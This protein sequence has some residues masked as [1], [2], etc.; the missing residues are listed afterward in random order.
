MRGQITIFIITI[1][2]YAGIW[3]LNPSNKA[4]LVMFAFF[5]GTLFAILR[6]VRL[7][8]LFGYITSCVILTGK[9]YEIQLI[10][11]GIFPLDWWPNGYL[12]KFIIT[13][14]HVIGALMIL[15]MFFVFVRK[16]GYQR[17]SVSVIDILVFGYFFWVL[18]SSLFGSGQ[19]EI[20]LIGVLLFLN[21]LVAYTFIRIE[22]LT[23]S[24]VAS[25]VTIIMAIV[26]F[27]SLIAGLQLVNHSPIG[28]TVESQLLLEDFGEAVDE[29]SFRFRP[30]GTYPH[31]NELGLALVFFMSI[32]AAWF[33]VTKSK[34]PYI[35]Y[36]AGLFTVIAT[37]SR[38][39]WLALFFSTILIVANFR[40]QLPRALFSYIYRYRY[41]LLLL[42]IISVVV[43]IVPR[44]ERSLYS[45]METGGGGYIRKLQF[46]NALTL[47][48]LHPLFGVGAGMNVPEGLAL[49]RFG[50]LASFPASVH[51]LYLLIA[52]ENGIPGLLIFLLI[53]VMFFLRNRIVYKSNPSYNKSLTIGS[54]AA[55]TAILVVGIFQPF[56]LDRLLFL[57][58]GIS[59]NLI[60]QRT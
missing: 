3:F 58:I 60:T 12:V 4:I 54:N 52:V 41:L 11:E 25:I 40:N 1:L 17:V 53:V 21:N 57:A 35:A 31:A 6:H 18:I 9:T 55:I 15:W 44:V 5:I 39:S 27:E 42:G 43:F 8:L 29:I 47:I 37:L 30:V 45:F 34:L 16:K 50:I 38:S 49:D 14:A 48:G 23:Q 2:F 24:A 22:K 59:E 26:L 20:S 13:P 32:L 51:N 19:P 56:M 10:P 46:E 28:K 7:S 36:G 33:Y